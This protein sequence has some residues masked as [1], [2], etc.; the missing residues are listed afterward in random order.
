MYQKISK[1]GPLKLRK[2]QIPLLK[3]LTIES[4]DD[5]WRRKKIIMNVM[6]CSQAA[7]KGTSHIA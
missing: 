2:L 4:L 1:K 6:R 5:I 3:E 7:Q